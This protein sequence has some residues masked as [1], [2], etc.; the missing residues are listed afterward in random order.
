MF[1]TVRRLLPTFLVGSVLALINVSGCVLFVASRPPLEGAPSAPEAAAGGGEYQVLACRQMNLWAQG[2]RAEPAWLKTL[3]VANIPSVILVAFLR[4]LLGYVPLF[5]G[6]SLC[7]Q[8]WVCAAVFLVSST[9]QWYFFG[10][11]VEDRLRRFFNIS[12]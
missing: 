11:F 2:D 6:Q 12:A 5:S 1:K 4:M 9:L 3:V 7:V 10:A 8:S